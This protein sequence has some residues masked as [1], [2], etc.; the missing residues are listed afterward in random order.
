MLAL[1]SSS[2][3]AMLATQVL[4]HVV[5]VEVST[6]MAFLVFFPDFDIVPV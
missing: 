4:L 6:S 3:L 2:K 5:E 1:W